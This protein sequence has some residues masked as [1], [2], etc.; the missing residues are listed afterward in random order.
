MEKNMTLIEGSAVEEGGCTVIEDSGLD[1]PFL[2]KPFLEVREGEDDY[3]HGLCHT[4]V[5]IAASSKTAFD[6]FSKKNH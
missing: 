3:L 4:E 5:S 6:P 1:T 2:M